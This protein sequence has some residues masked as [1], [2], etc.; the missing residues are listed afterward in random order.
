VTAEFACAMPAVLLVFATCL[1]AVQVVAQQTRLADAAASSA[2]LL[3]RGD[4]PG[5]SAAAGLQHASISSLNS[6]GFLCVDV[7]APAEVGSAALL[8]LTLRARSC[9]LAG[10]S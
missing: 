1:G 6:G 3:A 5:D 4:S 2:R 8:G 9:A 10:D 7:S